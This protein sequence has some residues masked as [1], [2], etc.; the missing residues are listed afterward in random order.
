[1]VGRYFGNDTV[2]GGREARSLLLRVS[3]VIVIGLAE[4]V[5]LLAG[6]VPGAVLAV[7]VAH[8]VGVHVGFLE[9]V[10]LR[11]QVQAEAEVDVV[12]LVRNGRDAVLLEELLDNRH[13]AQ[14]VR[15]DLVGVF[16][17]RAVVCGRILDAVILAVCGIAG[18]GHALDGCSVDVDLLVDVCVDAALD[19]AISLHVVREADLTGLAGL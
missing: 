15:I 17:A 3:Q 8:V 5:E 6:G 9:R 1:M 4:R 13:G 16:D 7:G 2:D 18:A 10:E 12:R 19:N 11:R 14:G